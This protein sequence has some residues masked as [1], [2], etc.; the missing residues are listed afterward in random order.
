MLGNATRNALN[1]PYNAQTAIVGGLPRDWI[2]EE[3]SRFALKL[4]W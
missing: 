4:H 1:S 3:R 2:D